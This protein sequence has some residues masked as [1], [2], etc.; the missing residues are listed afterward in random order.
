MSGQDKGQTRWKQ[1]LRGAVFL[2]VLTIAVVSVSGMFG[3]DTNH[4]YENMRLFLKEKPGSL[5]AVF[6]GSSAVHRFWLPLYG[7]A[8]HGLAVWNYSVDHMHYCCDYNNSIGC[9]CVF[10]EK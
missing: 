5:D 2:L 6:I 10:S 9:I 7:W 1:L 3:V 4:P 8:Q